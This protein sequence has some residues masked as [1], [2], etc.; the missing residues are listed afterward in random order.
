[1]IEFS[2]Y[3]FLILDLVITLSMWVCVI[4]MHGRDASVF[5]TKF[6]RLYGEQMNQAFYTKLRPGIY[7]PMVASYYLAAAAF[8]YYGWWVACALVTLDI[9]FQLIQQVVH[10]KH[11]GRV[12]RQTGWKLV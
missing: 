3:A 1:M 4:R 2:I 6:G 5:R 10:A 11:P 9:I 8:A 7:W 12:I